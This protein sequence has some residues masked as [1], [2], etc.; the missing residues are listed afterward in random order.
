MLVSFSQT[1]IGQAVIQDYSPQVLV[2][3]RK[4]F[5]KSMIRV[6]ECRVPERF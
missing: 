3:Y 5:G 1:A 4:R 6:P 2:L